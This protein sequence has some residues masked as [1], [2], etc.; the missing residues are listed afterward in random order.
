MRT[1]SLAALA[2]VL[3]ASRV[4]SQA[5]P[6]LLVTVVDPSGNEVEA[7]VTLTDTNGTQVKKEND[8]GGVKFYGLGV[9]PVTV[10]VGKPPCNQV[11]VRDVPLRWGDT[12]RVKVVY[13]VEDCLIDMP[14]SPACGVVIRVVDTDANPVARTS[15][16]ITAPQRSSATG[17]KFGRYFIN[18]PFGRVLLADVSAA[19]MVGSSIKVPC[20]RDRQLVDSFVTLRLASTK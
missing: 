11:T 6:S 17:D 13:N 20:E 12:V 15:I 7:D 18:V 5:E 10:V 14:H 9:E 16:S 1:L 4:L 3:F 19:G 2:I 8:T